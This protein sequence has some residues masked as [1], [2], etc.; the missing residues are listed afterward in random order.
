[1][2]DNSSTD[3]QYCLIFEQVN[4]AK[5]KY[6]FTINDEHKKLCTVVSSAYLYIN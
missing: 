3:I 6:L 1:M 5:C 2:V 4:L